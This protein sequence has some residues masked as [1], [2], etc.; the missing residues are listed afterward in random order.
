MGTIPEASWGAAAKPGKD[1]QTGCVWHLIE[2]SHEPID[3]IYFWG[4]TS[5]C[6]DHL[7]SH[8]KAYPLPAAPPQG[9][10]E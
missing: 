3:V 2:G 4:G 8:A 1:S 5:V 10:H 9:P 6:M 7:I